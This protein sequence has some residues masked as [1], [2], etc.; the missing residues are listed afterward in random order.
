MNFAKFAP[1]IRVIAFMFSGCCQ[2]WPLEVVWTGGAT[3]SFSELW[4]FNRV[5]G[6]IS[7]F[8][9]VCTFAIN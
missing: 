1:C 7:S 6:D 2:Q 9:V 4:T 8:P 5:I 3:F